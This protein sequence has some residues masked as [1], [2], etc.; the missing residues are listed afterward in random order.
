MQRGTA[1][2]D[3]TLLGDAPSGG[4]A[5]VTSCIINLASTCMGTGILALPYAFHLS[6]FAAGIALS[7]VSAGI[8]VLSLYMLIASGRR[9]HDGPVNFATLCEAALPKSGI[10][11]DFMVVA[12]CLGTACS[13]LIVATDC[14]SA[15]GAPRSA[16]VLMGTLAVTPAALFRSMDTLKASS[17]V[18][19]CCLIGIVV[20]VV[21]FGF[22]LADPCPGRSISPHHH[23]GGKVESP[24]THI[25]HHCPPGYL[26][27]MPDRPLPNLGPNVCPH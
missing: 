11:I 6:G 18:A 9:V 27:V 23:C 17:S 2:L 21:C 12:N 24:L 16:C 26:P 14:F 4:S 8:C 13:Y 1:T 22:G 5:S 19:I 10:L 7:I 15:L 3:R 25:A 20:M